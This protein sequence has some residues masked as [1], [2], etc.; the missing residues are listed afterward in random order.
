MGLELTRRSHSKGP[1]NSNTCNFDTCGIDAP[2]GAEAG[3][4]PCSM[5]IGSTAHQEYITDRPT[6]DL[7]SREKTMTVSRRYTRPVIDD[8]LASIY[9]E[10]HRLGM[11]ISDERRCNKPLTCEVEA[12]HRIYSRPQIHGSMCIFHKRQVYG[13]SL[14][15]PSQTPY[16]SKAGHPLTQATPL[17][18]SPPLCN[19]STKQ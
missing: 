11:A 14:D 10:M 17:S 9:V 5:S 2:R 4:T 12:T 18:L 13:R 7:A 6:T 15:G 3:R 16:L 8:L 19:L 1:D